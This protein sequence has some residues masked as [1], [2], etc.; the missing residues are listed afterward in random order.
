MKKN[1][2]MKREVP[3]HLMMLPGL[4]LLLIF[5]YIPMASIVIAFQKFI[6]AKGLFGEQQWIGLEN[7]S[8]VM[9]LLNFVGVIR[10]TICIA[11]GKIVLGLIIPMVYAMRIYHKNIIL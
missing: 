3:L 6:P 10:N 2:K 7:F 5:S 4:I 1:T 11:F 8:Y 9:Q